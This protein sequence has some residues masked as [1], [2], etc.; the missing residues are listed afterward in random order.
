MYNF[1]FH[2]LVQIQAKSYYITFFSFNFCVIFLVSLRYE[3]RN[4]MFLIVCSHLFT[5]VFVKFLNFSV[6]EATEAR[7]CRLG[8]ATELHQTY[9]I[10]TKATTTSRTGLLYL[11]RVTSQFRPLY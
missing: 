6:T 10:H 4:G 8:L 3:A 5:T 2:L 11:Q 1:A 9:Y 7:G